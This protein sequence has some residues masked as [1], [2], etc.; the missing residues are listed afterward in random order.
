M[1]IKN[2]K[3]AEEVFT[4]KIPKHK[5]KQFALYLLQAA[6]TLAAAFIFTDRAWIAVIISLALASVLAMLYK[7]PQPQIILT[8]EPFASIKECNEV[9]S[10]YDE[11]EELSAYDVSQLDKIYSHT[12]E[13]KLTGLIMSADA[14]EARAML[15]SF[16]TA[17]AEIDAD[18]EMANYLVMSLIRT[19]VKLIANIKVKDDSKYKFDNLLKIIKLDDVESMRD[20]IIDISDSLCTELA[21]RKTDGEESIGKRVEKYVAENYSN[22]ELDVSKISDYLGLSP[23]YAT[24]LFKQETGEVLSGYINKIRVDK[25]KELLLLNIYRVEQIA[26]MVGYLDSRALGRAFK[27]IYGLTPSQYKEIASIEASIVE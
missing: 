19:F 22:H 10:A 15:E 23:S 20:A 13:A 4:I 26:Q 6:V 11:D 9:T 17:L 25:A 16:F 27:R 7:K 21:L 2:R 5:T 18:R 14:S 12:D 1:Q 3:I 8:R 24:K